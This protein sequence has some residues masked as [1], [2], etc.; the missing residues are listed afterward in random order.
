MIVKIRCACIPKLKKLEKH[1]RKNRY[2]CWVEKIN[3]LQLIILVRNKNKP[4]LEKIIEDFETNQ[5]VDV[6][7]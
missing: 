5:Q 7:T 4:I 6:T 2:F 3:Y 1:L